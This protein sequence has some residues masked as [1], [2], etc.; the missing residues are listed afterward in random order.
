MNEQNQLELIQRAYSNFKSGDIDSLINLMSENIE[1][2]LPQ[3]ENVPFSGQR[4]GKGMVRD[5]FTTLLMG[6]D[7]LEFNPREFICQNDK[8]VALGHYEWKTKDGDQFGSDFA[9]V[10]TVRNGHIKMFQDYMDTEKVATV[11]KKRATA[12]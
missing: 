6:Q 8:V 5:F 2:T 7:P 3:V 11:Y 9:H 4:Q 12:F 10:F 1:W